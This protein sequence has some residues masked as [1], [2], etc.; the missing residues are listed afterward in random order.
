[1]ADIVEGDERQ[2]MEEELAYYEETH[3][4]S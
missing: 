1:M 4:G 3:G 2:W